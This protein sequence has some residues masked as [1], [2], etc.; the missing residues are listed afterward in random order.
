[1][2]EIDTVDTNSADTP[3]AGVCPFNRN[4]TG[5]CHF[6]RMTRHLVCPAP[7]DNH[8][9]NCLDDRPDERPLRLD[10]CAMRYALMGFGFLNVGIGLVGV[11]VPGL[12]TTVFLLVAVWA[13]SR[14]SERF[15]V[16]L[17][18]HPRF[19]PPIRAWHAHRAIPRRAKICAVSTM[20]VSLTIIILFI[21]ESWVLP[22]AVGTCM[23]LVACFILTR[24]DGPAESA[25]VNA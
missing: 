23:A 3:N 16:W 15:H 9:D 4:V 19:G 13:F 11:V 17:Y 14:S 18:N 6:A 10:R 1:M 2:T 12:P 5:S 25:D 20:A 8:R 7:E 22:A 24:P 21:A